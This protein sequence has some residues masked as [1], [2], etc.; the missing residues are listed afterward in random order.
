MSKNSIEYHQDVVTYNQILA[1]AAEKA[2]EVVTDETVKKWCI[3][4]GRQHRAHEKRHINFANKLRQQ[5]TGVEVVEKI[6]DT[7]DADEISRLDAII[8]GAQA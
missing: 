1:E 8:E 6:E 2:A 5:E 4:I 3:G 7:L